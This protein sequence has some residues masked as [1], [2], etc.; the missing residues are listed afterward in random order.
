MIDGRFSFDETLGV[1]K[2]SETSL[3][4]N[5]RKGLIAFLEPPHGPISFDRADVEA[6]LAKY[7]RPVKGEEAPVAS[8]NLLHMATE[9]GLQRHRRRRA[10]R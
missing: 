7:R 1:L 9:I 2:M 4:R 6:F 8:D 5:M 3:R 10:A